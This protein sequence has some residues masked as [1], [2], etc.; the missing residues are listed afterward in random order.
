[1]F[2]LWNIHKARPASGPMTWGECVRVAK[3]HHIVVPA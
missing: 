2:K 1:M 3:D